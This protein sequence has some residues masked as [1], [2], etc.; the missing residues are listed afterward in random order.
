MTFIVLALLLLAPSQEDQRPRA[1]Q[2][3]REYFDLAA[4]TG[5]DFYFWSPGEFAAARVQVPIHG[6]SVVLSYGSFEGKRL[7]EIPVESGVKQLTLFAGIQRKDLTVL[8]RPDG[9]VVRDG[10]QLFQHMLIATITSP[11]SGI[12]RLEL[13]GAGA[14]AVT[15]HVK[16]AADAPDLVSFEFVEPGGRPGHEGMFP[17]KRPLR[18]GESLA[19]SLSLEG[20]VREAELSF[21]TA[22]GSVIATMPSTADRCSVPNVPFRVLVRGIDGKGSPFQRIESPL[23]EPIASH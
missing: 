18:S 12:W 19:C 16:A 11:L 5:G 20:T 13:D 4:K 23:R 14:Y 15:A 3:N 21:V 8:V 9:T 7:F 17:I 2:F 22:D 1:P 10:V 6:E